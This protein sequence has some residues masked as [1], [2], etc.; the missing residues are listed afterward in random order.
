M[1]SNY[2]KMQDETRRLRIRLTETHAPLPFTGLYF[3]FQGRRPRII[4]QN[5]LSTPEKLC[6]LA[7]ELGHHHTSQGNLMNAC[8]RE[9]E[10]QETRAKKWAV[11]RLLPLDTIGEAYLLH[12]GDSAAMAE[13]LD[14]TE[15]FLHQA[16]RFYARQ[17]GV[18]GRTG[19]YRY[20]FEPFFHVTDG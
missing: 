15:T 2:E 19:R 20:Q 16:I 18:R 14:V 13:W 7:E 10:R 8:T 4:L 11:R 1:P 6:T 12:G 5:G 9:Y 17:F 3:R